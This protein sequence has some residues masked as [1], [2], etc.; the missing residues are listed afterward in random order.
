MLP[1]TLRARSRPGD[2][3]LQRHAAAKVSNVPDS[4]RKAVII[5][6][7]HPAESVCCD[8]SDNVQFALHPVRRKDGYFVALAVAATGMAQCYV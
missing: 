3:T 4:G 2:T 6:R 8:R 7:Q 5:D 1:R